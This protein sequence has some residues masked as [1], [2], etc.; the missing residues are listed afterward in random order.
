MTETATAEIH[1]LLRRMTDAWNAG[2]A[3]AYAGQFTEDADYITFF[4]MR[5]TGR[6][7]IEQS[8]R[9][10]FEGPLKGVKLTGSASGPAAPSIRFLRPDVA[11]VIAS[12]GSTLDGRPAPE[13]DSI[14]SL[15]AV[16]EPDA[17]RF[18]AFQNT[19]AASPEQLRAM[20]GAR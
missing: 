8:H 19:R 2:D 20:G 13:R 15:T 6:E 10:L 9:A 4:G 12:G 18:A 1:D 3:R 14:I 7:A 16:R 11:V 5:M 17:W